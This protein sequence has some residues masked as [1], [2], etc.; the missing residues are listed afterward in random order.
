M[1]SATDQRASRVARPR[2]MLVDDHEDHRE[3]L[4]LIIED[5]GYE[6]VGVGTAAAALSD[7]EQHGPPALMLLDR[8]LPDRSGD[9]LLAEL[10]RRQVQSPVVI[11]SGRE[12]GHVPG[13]TAHLGKPVDVVRLERL[14]AELAPLR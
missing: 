10:R 1:A 2:V 12:P 9:E 8:V 14:L 13:A 5:R 6:V 11:V 4:A 7:V 3:A